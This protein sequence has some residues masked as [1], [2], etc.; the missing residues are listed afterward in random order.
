MEYPETWWI[1]FMSGQESGNEYLMKI[2]ECCC[3]NIGINYTP[4]GDSSK[5]HDNNA[6]LAVELTL[7]FTEIFV[8]SKESIEEFNG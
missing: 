3:T 8:S 5:L 4:Q 7:D 6:P 1:K 2:N